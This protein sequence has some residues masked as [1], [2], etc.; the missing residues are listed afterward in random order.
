M[1][2]RLTPAAAPEVLKFKEAKALLDCSDSVLL[3]GIR[4]G[5]IP[6]F[7]LGRTWRFYRN[8]LMALG[9]EEAAPVAVVRAVAGKR[10]R[11]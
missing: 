11:G 2:G 5:F 8:D 4:T 6:A 9:G 1:G 3:D 7:K 10:G